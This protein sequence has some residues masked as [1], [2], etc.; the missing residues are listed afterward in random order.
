MNGNEFDIVSTSHHT[1]AMDDETIKGLVDPL[2][3][4]YGAFDY[5]WFYDLLNQYPE[6]QEDIKLYIYN[7]YP[8]ILMDEEFAWKVESMNHY[9]SSNEI[10]RVL[11]GNE[12]HHRTK[13]NRR[14]IPDVWE[15]YQYAA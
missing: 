3:G 7:N 2:F 13:N 11:S 12:D 1:E 8:D 15:W 5:L 6:N 10:F 9:W 14:S 4:E